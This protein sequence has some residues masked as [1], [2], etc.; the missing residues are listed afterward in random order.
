MPR[1]TDLNSLSA[2]NRTTLV[3]LMLQYINDAVVATHTTITHNDVH[4]FTGHRTYIEGMES[5]LLSNGG[6]QFVPLP[7]WNPANEVPIE[8]RVM[9]PKQD[10]TP[11]VPAS[12]NMPPVQNPNAAPGRA[13]PAQFAAPAVCSFVNGDVLGNAV[14]PWHGSVH[15]N[16]GGVFM[17]FTVASAVPLF[18]CWHA[19]VD[20]IYWDY[21]KCAARTD[22]ILWQH[23][24]G[25]VHYWPMQGGQRQGGI[26]I[27]TPVGSE[28]RLIGAGDVNGN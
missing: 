23:I 1:R 17:Q 8:F 24:N 7:K 2:A 5:F 19:F 9:K 18:W 6:G 20:E 12:P 10:G 3:N 26:D 11:W 22:D 21:Q 15:G 13:M 25:Q 4:I 28:W 27:A 14:N 16:V